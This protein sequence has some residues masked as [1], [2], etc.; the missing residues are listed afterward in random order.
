M[1]VGFVTS[2][3]TGFVTGYVGFVGGGNLICRC[4]EVKNISISI[5]I[6]MYAQTDRRL[7]VE[8]A[9]LCSELL[10]GSTRF[11]RAD[12]DS[13]YDFIR[14]A[15]SSFIC[16]NLNWFLGWFLFSFPNIPFDFTIDFTGD[17][18][19]SKLDTRK[20]FWDICKLASPFSLDLKQHHMC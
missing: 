6:C 10:Q 17:R 20:A 18:M 9:L 19:G 1:Y 3:V 13:H 12:T 8:C 5:C 14:Y 16:L 4:S 11:P 2:F 7:H 15:Y